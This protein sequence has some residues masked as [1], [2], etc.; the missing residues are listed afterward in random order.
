MWYNADYLS[1]DLGNAPLET[2]V[3]FH[4]LI[5]LPSDTLSEKIKSWLVEKMRSQPNIK[6]LEEVSAYIQS[7]ESYFIARKHTVAD[8]KIMLVKDEEKDKDVKCRICSKLHPK[9]KCQFVCPQYR[10]NLFYF[11]DQ[12]C[13]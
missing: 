2:L 10:Q 1:A 11:L 8:K 12:K 4:L 5:L 6:S 9:Y 7:E 3:L 13:F